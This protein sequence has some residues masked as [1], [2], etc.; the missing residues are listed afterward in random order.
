MAVNGNTPRIENQ[1]TYLRPNL[2][3]KRA[4]DHCADRDRSQ[5]HEQMDLRAGDR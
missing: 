2:S 4:A 5:E 1:I 3:P